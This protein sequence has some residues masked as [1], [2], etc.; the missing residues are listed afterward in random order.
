ME[1]QICK[2]CGIFLAGKSV[3]VNHDCTI[4]ECKICRERYDNTQPHNCFM[5]ILKEKR[6]GPDGELVPP[7]PKRY[8]IFDTEAWLNE[9][10]EEGCGDVRVHKTCCVVAMVACTSCLGEGSE[11]CPYCKTEKCH[12]FFGENSVGDFCDWLCRY[13]EEMRSELISISHNFSGYDVLFLL[14]HLYEKK[15]TPDVIFRG[16][17]VLMMFIKEMN[18]KFIDSL[19][20]LKMP[21][22]KMPKTLGFDADDMNKGYFPYLFNTEKNAGKVFNN[23]PDKYNYGVDKMS[24]SEIAEFEKW[25]ELNKN[26]S[27]DLNK[28]CIEYCIQDVKILSKA[29]MTF[30]ALFNKMTTDISRAP[31]GMDCFEDSF[32][33][34]GAANRCFRQIHLAPKTLALYPMGCCQSERKQSYI[35]ARWI[36]YLNI[37]HKFEPPI[38][39]ETRLLGRF[40]VDG[41]REDENGKKHVYELS[42]CWFHGDIRH[43]N[44]KIIHPYRQVSMGQLHD[45]TENRLKTLKDA[46]FIIH[47]SWECDFNTL[48]KQD[49]QVRQIVDSLEIRKPF[50]LHDALKG[51]RTNGVR[52]YCKIDPQHEKIRY[53]DVKSLYPFIMK[54]RLYPVGHPVV[55]TENFGPLNTAHIRYK[56]LIACNVLPPRNLYIPLLHYTCRGKLTFPLCRTCCEDESQES[57]THDA[58]AREFYGIYTHVELEKAITLGYKITQIYEIYEWK[59][60]SCDIFSSYIN[61]FFKVK[62]ESSGYP[63]HVQT[64]ADKKRH[65]DKIYDEEGIRLEREKIEYN[66]GMRNT[67]KLICN[68]LWGK[69]CQRDD[70]EKHMYISNP[71]EFFQLVDDDTVEV[72]DMHWISEELVF[73]RYRYKEGFSSPSKA[74]NVTVG[75]FTCAYGRLILFEYM[76]TVGLQNVLYFDTDSIIFLQQNIDC[77]T[78]PDKLLG[79]ALGDLTDELDSGDYIVEFVCGGPK[80]YMYRTKDGV[81]KVV[82]KGIRM[83]SA[84]EKVITFERLRDMVL[85]DL[86]EQEECKVVEHG[87]FVRD[88]KKGE[89]KCIDRKKLYRVVYNKR[90]IVKSCY[91]AMTDTVPFGWVD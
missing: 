64:E 91:N 85:K 5:P 72:R 61:T 13:Q 66:P 36:A 53:Y 62:E 47:H 57:C 69:M 14:K 27:F 74:A 2:M 87:F 90:R 60:W 80:H 48:I 25:Y 44:R 52:L 73:V 33:I 29:V 70:L 18:I 82:I 71:E 78:E 39:R 16:N 83:T 1:F 43:I 37:V 11:I 76:Q 67:S 46:G 4:S 84:T 23:L 81:I 20:Y 86:E 31:Y 40:T 55:I 45:E 21:L 22:K 63:S 42:G 32:T 89:V 68:T 26:N 58:Q 50:K 79:S 41:Y 56:G 19:N 30:R 75:I 35:G 28:E 17:K 65:I 12:T 10:D 3:V 38:R 49:V 34:A 9:S 77:P 7:P 24:L 51:G 54:N 15:S 88:V 8:V 59:D 6:R